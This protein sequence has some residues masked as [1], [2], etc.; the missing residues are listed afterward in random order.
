MARAAGAVDQID[1][2]D[3]IFVS[4]VL[5]EAALAAFAAVAAET[6]AGTNGVVLAADCHRPAVDPAQTHDIRGR[7]EFD[8]VARLIVCAAAG[9]FA[10]F[11]K[12]ARIEHAVDAL[13]HRQLARGMMPGNGFQPAAGFGELAPVVDVLDF[14]SPAHNHEPPIDADE[15][16]TNRRKFLACGSKSIRVY[17]RLS[18]VSL[19]PSSTA[20]T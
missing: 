11:A 18:A 5:H 2:R 13:A 3:T 8:E 6:G 14:N 19:Q 12:R 15:R 9:E 1:E 20:T 7:L 17:P 10:D 4:K 16:K